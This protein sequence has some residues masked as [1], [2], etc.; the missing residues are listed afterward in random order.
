MKNIKRVIP[1]LL[2]FLFGIATNHIVDV[3]LA[4]GGTTNL[5]HSCVRNVSGNIR[6]I[7]SNEVCNS[8][9]RALDWSG[10]SKPPPF[11]CSR[12]ELGVLTE[13]GVGNKLA[14]KDLTDS[15]FQGSDLSDVDFTETIFTN[16]DLSYLSA[17]RAN[18]T[19]ANLTNTNLGFSDLGGA[20]GLETA[21][22]T[23][24]IWANT[25]C[26]DTTNSDNN[27]NTCEGHLTP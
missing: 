20:I 24:T 27:G 10:N 13:G 4:H 8:G 26:P 16:A 19:N 1:F 14:G 15:F 2:V 6:I 25:I 5:I 11:F 12:C 23:N 3:A 22:L 18:F 21:T 7:G 17:N 9:E